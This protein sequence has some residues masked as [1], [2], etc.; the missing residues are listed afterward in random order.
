MALGVTGFVL[1]STAA[2]LLASR[3]IPRSS[4]DWSLVALGAWLIGGV[5]GL[6]LS[7]AIWAKL[8]PPQRREE[9]AENIVPD[10]F[11]D[12][13]D[14]NTFDAFGDPRF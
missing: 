3:G 8:F 9:L 12:G 10:Q 1:F 5:I 7:S 14:M 13:P 6:T 2:F 11:F 4:D